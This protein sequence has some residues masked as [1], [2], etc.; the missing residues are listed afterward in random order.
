[1][2]PPAIEIAKA[3]N[4]PTII[5]M[6]SMFRNALAVMVPPTASPKNMVAIFKIVSEAALD[7]LLVEIPISLTRLPKKASL[8][9]GWQMELTKEPCFQF[10]LEIVF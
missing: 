5:K 4:P 10:L 7:S 6:V 9:V 3:R 8:K 2:I 1:M